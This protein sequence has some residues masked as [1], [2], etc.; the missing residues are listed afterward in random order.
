MITLL[1]T[2]ETRGQLDGCCALCE[3]RTA[4]AIVE[5]HAHPTAMCRPCITIWRTHVFPTF[6]LSTSSQP[7]GRTRLSVPSP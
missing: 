5:F 2:E 4:V 3:T 7:V 6:V 1:S